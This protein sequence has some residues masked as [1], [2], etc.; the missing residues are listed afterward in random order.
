MCVWLAVG[1]LL[2]RSKI[3]PENNYKHQEETLI[4]WSEADGANLALSFQ[5][6]TGCNEIWE[7]LSDV[8]D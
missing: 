1:T 7:M 6:K 4:V 8:S 2:L 5:E 3:K